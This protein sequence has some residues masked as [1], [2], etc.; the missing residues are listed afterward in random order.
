VLPIED[1]MLFEMVIFSPLKWKG[2]PASE[3]QNASKR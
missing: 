1:R 2:D 3:C